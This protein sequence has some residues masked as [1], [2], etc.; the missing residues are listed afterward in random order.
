MECW[1]GR[2]K[3]RQIISME[4]KGKC[5]SNFFLWDYIEYFQN[6]FEIITIIIFILKCIYS[7]YF[8]TCFHDCFI[9]LNNGFLGFEKVHFEF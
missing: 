2:K 7:F 5:G 6:C 3:V 9:I 4:G 8:V 1:E